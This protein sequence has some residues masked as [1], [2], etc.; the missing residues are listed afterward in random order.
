MNSSIED[1]NAAAQA[2]TERKRKPWATPRVIISET[3]STQSGPLAA[4]EHLTPVGGSPS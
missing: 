4:P 3:R 2:A 1:A